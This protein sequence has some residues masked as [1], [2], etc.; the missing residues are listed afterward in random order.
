M[1]ALRLCIAVFALCGNAALAS[2]SY[3]LVQGIDKFDGSD[4][5]LALWRPM[6][7]SWP[8]RPTNTSSALP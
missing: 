5:A 1:K 3:N 6:V 8:I 2:Q 4:S 7:L